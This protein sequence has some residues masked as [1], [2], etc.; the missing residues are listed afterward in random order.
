MIGRLE[1]PGPTPRHGIAAAPA[2]V[3]A[4]VIA[5]LVVLV[6]AVVVATVAVTAVAS[7]RSAGPAAGVI[8][9][10]AAPVVEAAAP[11]PPS[12]APSAMA[13]PAVDAARVLAAVATA[14]AGGGGRV[15]V[16]VHDADGV[17]VLAGPDAGTPI[18]S[19]SLVKLLVVAGL[20][21]RNASGALALGAEDLALMQSALITS[22]DDAMSALWV[23]HDGARLVAE[24]AADLG[25][26][27]TAP[28]A[29]P[30]QWGQATTTA[31]DV[32]VLLASLDDLLDDADAGTM[33]TWLRSTAAT[34]A[35]GFDQAFGLLSGSAG[36]VGAKQGWM[37]CVDG[38]R[39]LH[40][41]GVLAD[42]RVVVLLGQ[43]PR[44]TPWA[45]ASTALDGAAAAVLAGIG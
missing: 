28:P 37:C 19:A 15:T 2:R 3:I 33:L 40:S 20:L 22:D 27:G 14:A 45:Q 16:A 29:V 18:Y 26:T 32:A 25:L 13:R 21:D 5:L 44:A 7:R 10:V 11:A 43:F 17:P 4:R 8:A 1:A 39:Q 34:A 35:D 36:A 31:A 41:A 38:G 12:A 9:S 30:G 24:T 6:V 23:R 42:G